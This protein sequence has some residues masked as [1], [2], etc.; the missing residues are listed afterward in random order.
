ML[1]Q[2]ELLAAGGETPILVLDEIA[3]HLDDTRR[4]ALFTRLGELGLQ[5][6]LSGTDFDDFAA[7]G[8][9]ALYLKVAEGVVG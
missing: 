4:T 3:A 5:A 8:G 6:W 7:L 2:A 9:G 1:A